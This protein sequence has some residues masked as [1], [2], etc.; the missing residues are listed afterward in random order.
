MPLAP[1]PADLVTFLERPNPAVVASIKPNGELHTAATWYEVVDDRTILLNMAGSRARLKYLRL[2]P[3]VA[4]TVTDSDDWYTHVSVTGSVAEI[5][6]DRGLTDID[7]LALRYTGRP[8]GD[9]DRDSWSAFVK[10]TR[11]HG[12]NANA[13]VVR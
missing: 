9:R 13:A 10:I 7:R 5:R 11:W 12:W 4:L 1:L 8:Y 2:D 3:R 6:A